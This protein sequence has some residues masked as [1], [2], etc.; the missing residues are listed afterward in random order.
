MTC[1]WV[2]NAKEFGQV[3]GGE[4]GGA[5][6]SWARV[7]RL[8]LTHIPAVCRRKG[9]Y[10]SR[11][12]HRILLADEGG[13]WQIP[14]A[15]IPLLDQTRELQKLDLLLRL[16]CGERGVIIVEAGLHLRLSSLRH[17]EGERFGLR[18][19]GRQARIGH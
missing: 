1:Q 14:M 13:C 8:V 6:S 5:C 17:W 4:S 10:V 18:L 16:G 12:S 19:I 2:L 15:L 3:L 7:L 9:S 11:R